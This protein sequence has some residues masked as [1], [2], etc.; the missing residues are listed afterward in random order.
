MRFLAYY[1]PRFHFFWRLFL[2]R[3]APRY[4]NAWSAQANPSD[5]LHGDFVATKAGRD[6][7]L[8]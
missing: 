3:I 2:L 8:K 6:R 7:P 1:I 4:L 5:E